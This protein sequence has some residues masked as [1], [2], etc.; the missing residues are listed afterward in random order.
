[1]FLFP[2]K[3]T[4]KIG[5]EAI[6]EATSKLAYSDMAKDWIEQMKPASRME[7][8]KL[9]LSQ[10]S[11]MMDI[12]RD[13]DP[14]PL[15]ELPDIRSFL[16]QSKV[17]GGLIPLDAFVDILV[18]LS[19]SRLT[20]NFLK[21]RKE[22]KEQLFALTESLVPL[23]EVESEI[24]AKVTDQG[25]LKDDASAELQNIRKNLNRKKNE[26]RSAIQRV[27]TRATKDGMTSEEGATIRNGRMVIPVLAEYKRKIQGFVHD[28]SS[29]GQ[30]VY[31]EP[32]EAL[33]L[34]NEIR[35]F[36]VEEQRE[37]ERILIELTTY[38]RDNRT[39]IRQNL[40]VLTE[41]DVI[42]AKAKLSVR[43]DGEIP[44]LSEQMEV[45]L[46]KAFNPNLLLKN[47]D[48]KEQ[49]RDEV[50]PLSLELD[51]DER[52]LMITGP[53]AGGKSVAMKTLG[54]CALM[55]QSGYAIPADANSELP[56][57]KGMF[58]DLGDDQSIEN[59][60]S[61][62]SSRL[63]WIRETQKQFVDESLVLID[64]AAAGT[65]PDEGSALFQAFLEELITD[66]V[67]IIVTTHHGGL[68]LF[69][70]EHPYAL[71]GSMEFDQASLSPTYKFKKGIPGSSYA[72]EIAER[73]K[74]NSSLLSRSR[75]LVGASKHKMESLISELEK[76][77]QQAEELKRKYQ[78]LKDKS[79]AEANKYKDKRE[80][81]ER[82]RTKIR[83]KALKEAK[84]IM[85]GANRRIEDAVSK[86]ATQKELKKDEIKKVR[87][88][89][90]QHKEK[91]DA[92]L[93]DIENKEE[94]AT[95][96][97]TPPD[98]G[99]FV[100]FKEGNTTGQ[101]MELD[102]KNAIVQADGLRIK[103][104]FKNLVKAPTPKGAG[105]KKARSNVIIGDSNFFDNL[106]HPT[107]DLRGMR[108]EEA[109]NEVTHYLDNAIFRGLTTVE[110]IHGKG[111]GILKDH[112]HSALH[113]RTDIIE[114]YHPK[115]D[116]G[117]AGCTVVVLN[118]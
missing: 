57:F 44:T 103:T 14:F 19:A 27:M 17:E 67:K 76:K 87:K 41:L 97:S 117:G 109:L 11:E 15:Q 77:T 21:S 82:E 5:F 42:L 55:N 90:N 28:I 1:M 36:E 79:V 75:E 49:E 118:S 2:S 102:G 110:L 7:R 80:T 31:L 22:H 64:E 72:F 108:A 50:I 35:Q 47:L 104:K 115:E 61:T 101:L 23:K 8:V 62:F 100:R 40:D 16:T 65:D 70:H 13:A 45:Q 3:V 98:V 71:N 96:D 78:S 58:V 33:Q 6:R 106:I 86:I 51:K 60:L 46:K 37:I 24:R 68:K 48:I 54:L 105:K 29:T 30:T 9:Q 26:L 91:I 84:S 66:P 73:M 114:F 99:D 56:V 112:I 83:E 63:H 89:V 94:A 10:A 32:V 116:Q 88:D 53:N 74:L 59:D 107:L 85:D 111:N 20:K 69:A 39:Y 18:V 12:I 81:I 52:C 43:L 93:Q 38:I 113:E 92:S 4:E 95:I 34:N 25:S